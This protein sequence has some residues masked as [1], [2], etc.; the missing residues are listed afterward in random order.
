MCIERSSASARCALRNVPER[1][2][3]N[4]RSTSDVFSPTH[5]NGDRTMARPRAFEEEAVL[6]AARSTLWAN[7][8]HATSVSDIQ[9]ATGLSSSSLYNAFGDKRGLTMA[10]LDDY[11]TTAVAI[12]RERFAGVGGGLAAIVDYLDLSASMAGDPG[13]TRGCYSVVCATE[14]AAVDDDVADRLRRHDAQLLALLAEELAVA[15]A[16]GELSCDPTWG[17][18]LLATAVNGVQVEARK[19]IAREDALTILRLALA[20]LR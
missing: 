2:L 6:A 19:G 11:L 18:R 5:E 7:G 15:N 13:P 1:M 8:I 16:R 3:Q 20:G 9:E 10:T 12:V 14:L 4:R 17:A